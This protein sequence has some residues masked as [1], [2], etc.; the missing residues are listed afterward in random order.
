[1]RPYLDRNDYESHLENGEFVISMASWKQHEHHV[2][3]IVRWVS[4]QNIEVG[5]KNSIMTAID[6]LKQMP[7]IEPGI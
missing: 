3:S 1:M 6:G 4:T 5:L 7:R 2:N